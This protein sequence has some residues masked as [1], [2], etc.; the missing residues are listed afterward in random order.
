[1]S[2]HLISRKLED[3]NMSDRTRTIRNNHRASKTFN[4]DGGVY[5][6][7]DLK[8]GINEGIPEEEWEIAKKHPVVRNELERGWIEPLIRTPGDEGEK[9]GYRVIENKENGMPMP[10]LEADV[11]KNIE[12]LKNG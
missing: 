10:L 5:G 3:I 11:S 1:M 8:P 7:I 6:R 9:E 2:K 4:Y 12:Q